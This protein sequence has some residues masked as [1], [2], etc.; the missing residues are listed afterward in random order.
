MLVKTNNLKIKSITPIIAPTDL[1]QVFPLSEEA[2]EIVTASRAAIKNILQGKDP[3]L[4]VVVGPCSIHDP[5]GAHEYAHK[6]GK[7]SAEVSDQLLLIMR[8]YFEKPR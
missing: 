2:S 8:V 5:Q 3:R 1:R 4:M 7:L 6:L